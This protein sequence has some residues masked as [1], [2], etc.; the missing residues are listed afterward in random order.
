M[1]V[2]MV[3]FILLV[4]GAQAAAGDEWTMSW[5]SA[6]DQF[7]L[8]IG[9]DNKMKLLPDSKI[10]GI[11][12]GTQESRVSKILRLCWAGDF[13]EAE[14]I[15]LADVADKRPSS[16]Q[17]DYSKAIQRLAAIY[18][19]QNK[20][21]EALAALD[22]VSDKSVQNSSIS[23]YLL[24][25]RAKA[26]DALGAKE[27]CEKHLRAA[28]AVAEAKLGTSDVDTGRLLVHLSAI[29]TVQGKHA[30]ADPLL[31]RG[32]AILEEGFGADHDEARQ[33]RA[34]LATLKQLR[35]VRVKVDD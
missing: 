19:A 7:R 17:A 23:A 24:Y 31:K 15:A 20:R 26:H 14:I 13:E 8:M 10:R 29:L 32:V 12:P 6:E 22:Q 1:R 9:A 28:L 21:E 5:L 27:E 3:A 18:N 30:E 16:D 33:A 11:D 25:E 34:Q 35:R 4:A 2:E